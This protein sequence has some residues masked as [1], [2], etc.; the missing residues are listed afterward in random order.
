MMRVLPTGAKVTEKLKLFKNCKL[1]IYNY[2]HLNDYKDQIKAETCFTWSRTYK[3]A[4][5][6]VFSETVISKNITCG[7]IIKSRR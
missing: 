6:Y 4:D 5:L 1:V 2:D 3:V 7:H